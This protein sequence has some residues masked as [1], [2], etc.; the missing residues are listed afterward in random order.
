MR[1]QIKI[2][3]P[4]VVFL[5]SCGGETVTGSPEIWKNEILEAEEAFADMAANEGIAKAFL[6]YA[7]EDAVVMRNNRLIIGRDRLAVYLENQSPGPENELLSW[8]PDFVE[9]STSGDLGYTYGQY[10][11]SYTDST[12]STI[13]NKGI[14]H[15]VWKRQEDGSWRFVWD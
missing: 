14:F 10:T 2:L 3:L 12:G 4:V 1:I 7:A 13:S 9:V 15:T 5:C 8:K 11:Y 6:N